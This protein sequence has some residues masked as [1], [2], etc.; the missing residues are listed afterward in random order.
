MAASLGA[1]GGLR[2]LVTVRSI[3]GNIQVLVIP[4]Q[5]TVPQAG[6]AFDD[7]GNL[8]DAKKLA[9]VHAIAARVIHI[10]AKLNG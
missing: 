8:K 7:S 4:D 6:Q 1:L 10:A 3:L 9:Q 2:G 5:V